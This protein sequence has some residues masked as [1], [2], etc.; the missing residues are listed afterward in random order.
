MNITN[1]IIKFTNSDP[2]V[3]YGLGEIRWQA[4]ALCPVCGNT[5]DFSLQSALYDGCIRESPTCNNCG[6][7]LLGLPIDAQARAL[8]EARRAG[9]GV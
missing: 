6:A 9:E 5:S 3:A 4:P 8:V 2:R 7:T 1:G